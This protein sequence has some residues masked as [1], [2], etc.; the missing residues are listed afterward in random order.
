M[1]DEDSESLHEELELRTA[2]A[3]LPQRR[4]RLTVIPCTQSRA[5]AFVRAHH[6]HHRPPV[7]AIFCLAIVDEEGGV[8]GVATVGR[9]VAR[10]L[11][12][13]LTAEVN[14]VATDG[15]S[16]ACSALLGGCRRVAFAMG[17]RRIITYTLPEE[18]GASLRGAGWVGDGTTPGGG[19]S[20]QKYVHLN[21]RDDH[22]LGPKQRWIST[23][24]KA[25]TTA[26]QW[27]D[28][29]CSTGQTDLFQQ[30]E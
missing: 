3:D 25:H 23:N 17:Y 11:D 18:G 14:R 21:R 28:F 16:N 8:R 4:S 15:C 2:L 5:K 26:V 12:D 30:L 29:G 19:W 24:S 7:G 20:S 22:P 9:P 10:G 1:T 27:P 6:R 13:G